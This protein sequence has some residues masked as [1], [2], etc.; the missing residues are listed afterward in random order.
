LTFFILALG[1]S[2]SFWQLTA[3]AG[4]SNGDLAAPNG[5]AGNTNQN[6]GTKSGKDLAHETFSSHFRIR[7]MEENL[8][9]GL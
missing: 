6:K 9:G 3:V 2:Q 8:F 7:G 5:G 4:D 1:G